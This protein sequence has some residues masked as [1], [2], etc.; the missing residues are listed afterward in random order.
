MPDFRLL[1]TRRTETDDSTNFT[2]LRVRRDVLRR[3]S[4]G[5]LF[6]NRSVSTVIPGAN[7]VFGVDAN[8]LLSQSIG[9]ARRPSRRLA[10]WRSV[11]CRPKLSRQFQLRC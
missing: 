8:L 1:R 9:L 3:S 7:Q 2:V 5:A 6:T 4:I 10:D 11:D